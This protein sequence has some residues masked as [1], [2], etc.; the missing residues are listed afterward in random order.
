M[1]SPGA[2]VIEI[3]RS[4]AEIL[5]QPPTLDGKAEVEFKEK[6]CAKS[7]DQMDWCS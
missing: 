5:Q 7:L 3:G 6:D 4:F 2:I 1:P